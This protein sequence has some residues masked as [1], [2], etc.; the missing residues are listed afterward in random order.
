M[1]LLRRFVTQH[2]TTKVLRKNAVPK[3]LSTP[4]ATLNSDSGVQ[5][6]MFFSSSSSSSTTTANEP[7]ASTTHEQ[8]ENDKRYQATM[9]TPENLLQQDYTSDFSIKDGF[10]PGVASY[11]DN[12]ATTPMDPRVLD[13]MMPMYMQ[14]VGNPHSRTRK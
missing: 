7:R 11:L 13:A 5:N 4:M 2:N 3:R 14:R 6:S 12:Q 8:M 9:D 1:L 10:L